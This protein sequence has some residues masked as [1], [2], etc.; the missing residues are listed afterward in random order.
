MNRQLTAVLNCIRKWKIATNGPA[1]IC[2]KNLPPPQITWTMLGLI[3]YR[4]R[5]RWAWNVLKERVPL[6]FEDDLD[7]M[8]T[9]D[10]VVNG[11]RT[12]IVPE[13]PQWEYRIDGND[14]WVQNRRSG[15]R[16]HVDV[17]N[18][19]EVTFAWQYVDYVQRHREPGP[20]EARLKELFPEGRGLLTAIQRLRRG[21][22]LHVLDSYWPVS[23]DFELC[24]AVDGY[25][26]GVTEFLDAWSQPENRIALAAQIGD[27]GAVRE[28]AE[29]DSQRD[30]AARAATL[31]QQSYARWLDHLRRA[32]SRGLYDDVLHALAHAH[33]EDL[34]DYLD[35]ALGNPDVSDDALEII[36]DD[37][38]W[39]PRVYQVFRASLR[40]KTPSGIKG[41][42]A[43][44]LARHGHPVHE[45]LAGLHEKPAD[46]WSAI[47]V[48]L[49]HAPEH[50]PAE[51]R[52]ALRSR[53][54]EQ[55]LLAAGVLA[56][57]DTDWSR[58]ELL[59]VLG[60]SCNQDATFECRTALRESR[61]VEA[62]RAVDQWEEEHP[63]VDEGDYTTDR[64]MHRLSGGCDRRL[65]EVMAHLHEPVLAARHKLDDSV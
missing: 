18:W 45:L 47:L 61:C 53:D 3:R 20:A 11:V 16:I 14:S 22:L 12:G 23:L 28:A 9:I 31:A 65:H 60:E 55:R 37:P 6:A 27:W 24:G 56:L 26:R 8:V 36:A 40:E 57:L 32:A 30:I 62:H 54:C 39:K 41:H 2:G 64:G 50:L 43:L 52:F 17:P 34:S 33:A 51:L 10:D 13:M 38:A 7:H 49:R 48:A 29:V 5:K 42:A 46:S 15:E 21:G 59:A 63:A 25:A 58:G 35:K 1:R 4:V 44:Y 19:P